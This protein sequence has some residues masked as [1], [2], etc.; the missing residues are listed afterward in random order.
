MKE[1]IVFRLEAETKK[2]F[3]KKVMKKG[4]SMTEVLRGFVEFYVNHD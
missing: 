4:R 1:R 2:K 3:Q